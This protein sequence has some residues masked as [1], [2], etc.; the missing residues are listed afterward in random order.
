MNLLRTNLPADCYKGINNVYIGQFDKLKKRDL[1]ALHYNNN[2][3]IDNHVES[4]KDLLDDLVHEFAHGFEE[5][6]SEALYEDGKIINEFLGK[7][8]R[9]HDLLSQEDVPELNYFDF[10]NLD[11]DKKF[12]E[13]LYK[14]VGYKLIRNVAP[15]LFIRPYAATSLREYFATGFES[16]Y[17]TGGEELKKISPI[18]HEKISGFD[19]NEKFKFS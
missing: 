2:L 6:N 10:L 17:L 4:E 7:R 3:Y 19:Q 16:F 13:F 18:L 14:K 11:F 9:L 12:D 1:T 8:N 15:T 5:V